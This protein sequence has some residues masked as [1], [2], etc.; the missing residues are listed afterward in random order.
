MDKQ[1]KAP[2]PI[3][4]LRGTGYV[5]PKPN[6][7]N[8]SKIPC[9][10]EKWS[11][12]PYW[13]L[14]EATFLICGIDP[15]LASTVRLDN[16]ALEPTP[17]TKKINNTQEILKRAYQMGE[18]STRI[19]PNHFISWAEKHEIEF[20][21][22]LKNQ[23]GLRKKNQQTTPEKSSK[24]ENK[25]LHTRE[26]ETLL[27]III[28][29]AVEQYGYDPAIKRN[30][31]TSNIVSDLAVCGITI[32]ADTVRDKLQQAAELLPQDPDNR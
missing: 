24:E 29:M 10:F 19:E 27:K 18:L 1:T 5:K 7:E 31:A 16:L 28:G 22:E 8:A 32:D 2:A 23:V 9:D 13:D 15:D 30:D 21:D 20:P 17:L 25:I 11:K 14:T 4:P 12:M 3:T 26:R 6:L